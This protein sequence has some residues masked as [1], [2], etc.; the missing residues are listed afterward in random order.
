MIRPRN[1]RRKDHLASQSPAMARFRPENKPM[2][3]SRLPNSMDRPNLTLTVVRPPHTHRLPWSDPAYPLPWS[4][5]SITHRGR[6]G[7]RG[8]D[9]WA[10]CGYHVPNMKTTLI[11]IRQLAGVRIPS[12]SWRSARL[13]GEIEMDVRNRAIILRA[14]RRARAGWDKASAGW[15]AG[16]RRPAGPQAAGTRWMTRTGNGREPVRRLPRVA[17][18]HGR[19]RDQED[20]PL[21]RDLAGRDEPP[22]PHH[23]HR[24][25]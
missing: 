16:R 9:A 1:P 20:A 17:G 19:P 11:P 12:R 10:H 4:D 13:A 15:P 21:R 2:R 25:D 14:P 24:P 22:Y 23:H 8:L 5:P 6:A 7:A 3:P 18:P